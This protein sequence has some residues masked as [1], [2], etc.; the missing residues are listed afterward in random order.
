MVPADEITVIAG[1]TVSDFASKMAYT[2][3]ELCAAQID[4]NCY[5]GVSCQKISPTNLPNIYFLTA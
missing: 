3:E 5:I 2:P 1:V 4:Y